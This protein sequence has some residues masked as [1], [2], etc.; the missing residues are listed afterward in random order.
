MLVIMF[1]I[2]NM[3]KL[4]NFHFLI[5]CSLVFSMIKTLAGAAEAG[6]EELNGEAH[7]V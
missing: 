1:S 6:G 5:I 4:K 2:T 3:I 7:L